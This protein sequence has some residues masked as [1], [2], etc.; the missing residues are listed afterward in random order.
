MKLEIKRK[1]NN[2]NVIYDD[3]FFIS[4][5]K[6]NRKENAFQVTRTVVIRG[7]KWR[8]KTFFPFMKSGFYVFKTQTTIF[9][10]I[11]KIA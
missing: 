6:K 4:T 7:R 8:K 3:T 9:P 10:P 11:R 2:L 1:K 5:K